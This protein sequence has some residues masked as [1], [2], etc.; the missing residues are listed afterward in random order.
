MVDVQQEIDES[1]K[2]E[3]PAH[4]RQMK[5]IFAKAKLDLAAE[6]PAKPKGKKAVRRLTEVA[7][8]PWHPGRQ[9]AMDQLGPSLGKSRGT[10][11]VMKLGK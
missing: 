6:R 11:A 8:N 4:R 10:R 3:S 7:G 2:R 1:F 9:A 5:K